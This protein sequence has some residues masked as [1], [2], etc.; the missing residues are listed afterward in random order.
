MIVTDKKYS[1]D[2][3]LVEKLDLMCKRCSE[4]SQMDNWVV[5]DGDEGTGKST[6]SIEC[7]YYVAQ[8]LGRKFDI[9]NIFFDPEEMIKFGT[10]TTDQV[11]VMDESVLGGLSGDAITKIGKRLVKF[12]MIVRKKRHFIFLNIP[13]FFK[14]N[15]YLMVDRS[16]GLIHVYARRGTQLGR[17]VYFSQKAKE[18]LYYGYKK[19]KRRDYKMN[20]VFRGS[21]PNALG[22]IIDEDKYDKKK[23]E[24]IEKFGK[25]EDKKKENLKFDLYCNL[26]KKDKELKV[27]RPTKEY[28]EMLGVDRT[29]ISKYNTKLKDMYR[30]Q[31]KEK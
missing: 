16:V 18:K 10:S 24:T 22:K 20:Y 27:K 3:K 6:M 9:N 19:S 7:A 28:A 17:F 13:K 23:D 25:E 5:V 30:Y 31:P 29:L 15:E 14:L 4:N 1:M 2:D 21:F 8:K 26:L 11:I 12:A